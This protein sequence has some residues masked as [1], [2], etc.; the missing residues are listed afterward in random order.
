M[1]EIE[2]LRAYYDETDQ[3]EALAHAVPEESVTEVLVFTSIRLPKALMDQVRERA[4]E[5]GAPATALM[6]RWIAD[7]LKLT[8]NAAQVVSVTELEQFIAAR[9]HPAES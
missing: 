5:A 8:D 3:S 1:T 2:R 4:A 9:A 7:R 6:R